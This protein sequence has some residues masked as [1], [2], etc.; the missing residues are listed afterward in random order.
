MWTIQENIENVRVNSLYG[1]G[2][3]RILSPQNPNSHCA[4]GHGSFLSE[5]DTTGTVKVLRLCLSYPQWLGFFER[6]LPC[7]NR[8][9]T[10]RPNWQEID[11]LRLSQKYEALQ[12]RV[13]SYGCRCIA[14][15][16]CWWP[17]G[18]EALF[19]FTAE[20]RNVART[21]RTTG[22]PHIPQRWEQSKAGE[23]EKNQISTKRCQQ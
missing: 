14:E 2:D 19:S 12:G 13:S 16:T 5:V 8:A 17:G 21:R 9:P 22:M 23:W 18:E 7:Q 6:D 1:H 10:R 20:D 11:L 15:M 3:Y 4:C